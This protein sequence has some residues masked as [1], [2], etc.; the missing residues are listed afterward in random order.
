VSIILPKIMV[1]SPKYRFR[2]QKR[3]VSV[4]VIEVLRVDRPTV[5]FECILKQITHPLCRNDFTPVVYKMSIFQFKKLVTNN[6]Y[7][8][9]ENNPHFFYNT[10][11]IHCSYRQKKK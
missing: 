1:N 4:D 6:I 11:Y 5:V 7:S 2:I 3:N 8:I 9:I 10:D